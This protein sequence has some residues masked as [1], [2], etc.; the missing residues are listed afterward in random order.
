[1]YYLYITYSIFDVCHQKNLTRADPLRRQYRLVSLHAHL[2]LVHSR[3][4]PDLLL[5]LSLLL[6]QSRFLAPIARQPQAGQ[7]HEHHERYGQR[8]AAR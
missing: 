4:P 1:M 5:L 2:S 7:Y 6:R 3:L 8:G